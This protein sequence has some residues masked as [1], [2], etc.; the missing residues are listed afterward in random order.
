M[1][2]SAPYRK[3]RNYIFLLF[4]YFQIFSISIGNPF[5]YSLTDSSFSAHLLLLAVLPFLL[6]PSSP[7]NSPQL[8]PLNPLNLQLYLYNSNSPC[9][10]C[11][12]S[13]AAALT[14]QINRS[15]VL[16]LYLTKTSAKT[17]RIYKSLRPCL[18]LN[19]QFVL[20]ETHL[21]LCNRYLSVFINRK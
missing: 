21:Y 3:R 9:P 12:S 19:D 13:L 10:S 2:N 14:I 7:A 5:P 18:C 17:L 6:S 1:S 15:L 4:Q 16:L 8:V 11:F 20:P